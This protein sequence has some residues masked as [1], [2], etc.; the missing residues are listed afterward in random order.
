MRSERR[1]IQAAA[2][3]AVGIGVRGRRVGAG[4]ELAQVATAAECRPC[5]S[6]GHRLDSRIGRCHLKDLD[7]L[8][9]HGCAELVVH[10]GPVEH[11]LELRAPAFG[12]HRWSRYGGALCRGLCRQPCGVLGTV[13]QRRVRERLD[14]E[15]IGDRRRR[16]CP[17]HLAE[18]DRSSRGMVDRGHQVIDGLRHI[19]DLDPRRRRLVLRRQ[20]HVERPSHVSLLWSHRHAAE[21][22]RNAR[23]TTDRLLEPPSPRVAVDRRGLEVDEE[24]R[25]AGRPS[26]SVEVVFQRLDRIVRRPELRRGRSGGSRRHVGERNLGPCRY[27]CVP[28]SAERR[29]LTRL[30]A[31]GLW[32]E[33]VAPVDPPADEAGAACDRLAR[34]AASG[35][36]WLTGPADGPPVAPV[37]DV[38]HTIDDLTGVLDALPGGRAA[39]VDLGELVAALLVAIGRAQ[40]GGRVSVGGATRLLLAGD[41]TWCAISL[42]RPDDEVSVEAIVGHRVDGDPW[43]AL[44][45]AASTGAAGT[46]VDRAQLLGVPAAVLAAVQ[47]ADA[48]HLFATTIIGEPAVRGDE[49]P[50]VIDLTAM[51]AG[52]LCARLLGLRG[53]DI[54]KVEDRRRPDGARSGPPAF[55]DWLHAGHRSVALDLSQCGDRTSL[56]ALLRRADVVLEG[57]RARAL[58]QLGI[59]PADVGADR[60]GLT[61]VSITGYGRSGPWADRVAFGDD[62]AVAGGLVALDDHEA[63]LFC[64]DALADP[65]AGLAAAVAATASLAV[66]GGRLVEVPLQAVANHAAAGPPVADHVVGRLPV[67]RP[68]PLTPTGSAAPLG[69]RRWRCSPSFGDRA[70]RRCGGRRRRDAASGS[71]AVGSHRS[72]ATCHHDEART[73]SRV[74]EERSSPGCTTTMSISALAAAAQSVEVGPPVVTTRDALAAALQQA[75]QGART[76]NWVRAIG[77]HDSVAGPLDRWTLDRLVSDRPVR[78]Q[79]RSG[80]LWI[81]NSA[82]VVATG[83]DSCAEPGVERDPTGVA[84]GR[85]WRMDRWLRAA[86]PPVDVDA[87]FAAVSRSL[88]AVGFTGVTD[89]TPDREPEDLRDLHRCALGR[90]GRSPPSDGA[91]PSR[92]ARPGAEHRVHRSGEAD[93]RRRCTARARRRDRSGPSSARRRAWPGRAL[94]DRHPT[95]LHARCAG[96]CGP[97]RRRPR[98][99]CSRGAARPGAATRALRPDGRDPTELRGRAGRPLPGR[100]RCTGPAVPLSRQRLWCAPAS[101]WLPAPTHP[102]VVPTR[103]RRCA[104]A[105][106]RRTASG[107]SLGPDEA[108]PPRAA[109]ALFT[110]RADVPVV[111]RRIVAREP[112]DLCLLAAPIAEVLADPD[113]SAVRT[114]WVAGMPPDS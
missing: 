106:D 9:A 10:V 19:G 79:H 103:G 107:A 62:A 50:L 35:A 75:P 21:C 51:W 95:R 40:R 111:P 42:A 59:W 97:A 53:A 105:I 27:P 55:Y 58:D 33:G 110:G 69:G 73:S 14:D 20:R 109:L 2:L 114:T 98:R 30:A 23:S 16:L 91:S 94:R 28:P 18:R 78:V 47:P 87:G 82:A 83:L 52:P 96:R 68:V 56:A 15:P 90:R 72:H 80:A 102:S 43:D 38:V 22:H 31:S 104:C 41:G 65:L 112:A 60:P 4:T 74:R 81:L 108:L 1:W 86:L 71:P 113:A 17:Q 6:P 48:P 89:A 76:G 39:T 99:A 70:A 46:F 36:L 45:V 49:P 44:A 26:P 57:S 64:A 77:Y 92:P 25:G 61:W 24:Q 32:P 66:G 13:L 7:Q 5:S 34:W 63:P 88:R 12:T 84:T 54:V 85:L 100:G 101:G 29:S 67:S 8:V 37:A 93:A 11:D 3:R